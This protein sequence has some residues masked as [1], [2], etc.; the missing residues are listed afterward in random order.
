MVGTLSRYQF[1][2]SNSGLRESVTTD[3]IAIR[4]NCAELCTICYNSGVAP[5]CVFLVSEIYFEFGTNEKDLFEEITN[6]GRYRPIIIA[7]DFA[8][9]R[10]RTLLHV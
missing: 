8:R 7:S 2:S 6:I 9:G 10:G 3:N 5:F 1:F 4:G